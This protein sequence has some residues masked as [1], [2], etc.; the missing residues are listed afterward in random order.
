ML[1][2]LKKEHIGHFSFFFFFFSGFLVVA[3]TKKKLSAKELTFRSV[4]KVP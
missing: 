2:H 3:S 4:K 1:V